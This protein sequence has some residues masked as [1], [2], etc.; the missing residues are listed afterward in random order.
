MTLHFGLGLLLRMVFGTENN[1]YLGFWGWFF[2]FSLAGAG[3]GFVRVRQ[4]DAA[5]IEPRPRGRT[6]NLL[7]AAF[8]VPVF[9]IIWFTDNTSARMPGRYLVALIVAILMVVDSIKRHYR[10][11]RVDRVTRQV[12]PDSVEIGPGRSWCR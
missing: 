8:A 9:L 10:R 6:D 1:D 12:V 7:W 5:G 4:D 3:Y 11:S 2:L